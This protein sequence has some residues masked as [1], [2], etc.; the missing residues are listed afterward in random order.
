MQASF[1]RVVAPLPAC[2]QAAGDRVH[3]Q[4]FCLIAAFLRVDRCAQP[5]DAA[6]DDLNL[7][8]VLLH[9]R[10]PRS[11][12]LN[13]RGTRSLDLVASPMS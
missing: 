3:L 12:V 8:A 5:G 7:P 4:H 6:A 1:K 13:R 11:L 10:E 2:R 9:T